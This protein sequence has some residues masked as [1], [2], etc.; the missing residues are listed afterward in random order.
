MIGQLAADLLLEGES[1]LFD[2]GAFSVERF[3]DRTP[4]QPLPDSDDPAELHLS[5]SADR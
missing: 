5:Q 1:E 3:D 2:L 4:N